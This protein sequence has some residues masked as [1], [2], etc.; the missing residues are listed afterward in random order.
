[1]NLDELGL[2]PVDR[3][4]TKASTG[5]KGP[6][7]PKNEPFDLRRGVEKN[8]QKFTFTPKSWNELQLA[9]NS[10]KQFNAPDKVIVAIMPG[11][12]GVFLKNTAKGQKGRA[13]KNEELA[14]ALDERGI[15]AIRFGMLPI[16]EKDGARYYVLSPVAV[17]AKAEAQTEAASA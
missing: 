15:T 8:S 10:A 17:A 2:V 3:A 13:F 16:G 5:R 4:N 11:N 12:T 9:T 7:G 6:T 14:K 1:M